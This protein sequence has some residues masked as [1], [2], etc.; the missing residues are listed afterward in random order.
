MDT[1]TGVL[2]TFAAGWFARTVTRALRDQAALVA[3]LET[4]ALVLE[5][6]MKDIYPHA[7]LA[8]A[9]PALE[10]EVYCLKEEVFGTA[11]P[12]LLKPPA[13]SPRG[14]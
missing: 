4:R 12:A 2:A 1:L 9:I 5:R 6:E 14:H 11:A 10:I 3:R 8:R 7:E 13:R